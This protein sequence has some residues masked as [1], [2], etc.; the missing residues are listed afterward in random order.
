[1]DDPGPSALATADYYDRAV[2]QNGAD[3]IRFY[4]LPGVYHCGGGPGA[5]QMDLITATGAVGGAGQ[6]TGPARGEEHPRRLRAP[7]LRMAED[8]AV[9]RW[10]C[11]GGHELQVRIGARY[12]WLVAAAMSL[13]LFAADP[14]VE[15]DGTTALHRAVYVGRC[16]GSARLIAAGADVRA[17]NLFG[18][19]PMMLAAVT[20]NTG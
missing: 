6:G 19:T 4:G 2:K 3:N 7:G 18:A 16:G 9:H 12:L 14:A 20:G 1:M 17:A 5:D 11:E 13:P 10:R 8:A 15:P